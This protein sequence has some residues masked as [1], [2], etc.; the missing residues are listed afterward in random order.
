MIS[1]IRSFFQGIVQVKDRRRRLKRPLL[2]NIIGVGFI[3]A[4]FANLVFNAI[5]FK[6]PLNVV[7][8]KYDA[9][10]ISLLFVA[11]LVGLGILHV[12]RWGWYTFIVFAVGVLSYNASLLF[13]HNITYNWIVL[14][15][16]FILLVMAGFVLQKDITAPYFAYDKRG[17][18]RAKRERVTKKIEINKHNCETIDI[19]KL[20]VLVVWPDC[21]LD[22]GTEVTIDLKDGS[23]PITAGI[24]RVE[25]DTVGLAY[26][27]KRF[28]SM[29]L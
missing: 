17:F 19:S 29:F 7:F 8:Y 18:R 6:M 11:P 21:P 2:L 27:N 20:G 3:V 9:L 13:K 26:R 24:V 14:I 15:H 25:G 10:G 5:Y 16:S 12:K 4:P 28:F 22:P 23:K 1:A